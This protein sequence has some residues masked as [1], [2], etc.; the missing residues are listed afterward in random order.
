[1]R[2]LGLLVNFWRRSLGSPAS[3]T[4]LGAGPHLH[5]HR[6]IMHAS[7][8]ATAR[9]GFEACWT[10]WPIIANTPL[11][12]TNTSGPTHSHNAHQ[13]CNAHQHTQRH[14]D[15]FAGYRQTSALVTGPVGRRPNSMHLRRRSAASTACRRQSRCLLAEVW[16]IPHYLL[17]SKVLGLT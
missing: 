9:V 15:T 16:Y 11:C 14:M 17:T 5:I 2:K 1:V 7:I 4:S 8:A 6:F 13:S 10:R 12:F 3:D